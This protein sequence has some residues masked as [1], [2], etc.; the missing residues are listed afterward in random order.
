MS[1]PIPGLPKKNKTKDN[2]NVSYST[3]GEVSIEGSNIN[4]I[5]NKDSNMIKEFS[6]IKKESNKN[7]LDE[8]ELNNSNQKENEEKDNPE[9]RQT[10]KI[11]IKLVNNSS[12]AFIISFL[13]N[14][15]S[16]KGYFVMRLIEIIIALLLIALDYFFFMK[17]DKILFLLICCGIICLFCLVD[18]IVKC[19]VLRCNKLFDIEIFLEFLIIF[20]GVSISPFCLMLDKDKI[21]FIFCFCIGATSIIKCGIS[22]AYMKKNI[23]SDQV[24]RKNIE[25]I[26]RFDSVIY[27]SST[28]KSKA[29]IE[30]GEELGKADNINHNINDVSDF[31]VHGNKLYEEEANE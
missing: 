19:I 17:T 31:K 12:E 30:F 27:D 28:K 3:G 1:V 26:I 8:D 13:N 6:K 11:D 14:F 22:L 18:I 10:E 24:K 29:E 25:E 2:S 4:P 23:L 20:S 5:T 15:M 21:F 7:N 9:L 16:S